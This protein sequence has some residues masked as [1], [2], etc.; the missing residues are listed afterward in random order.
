LKIFTEARGKLG[1]FY[2]YQSL[3][4]LNKSN[5]KSLDGIL[6]EVRKKF[7]TANMKEFPLNPS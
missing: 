5:K 6:I 4:D 2:E 7:D 1:D 3:E